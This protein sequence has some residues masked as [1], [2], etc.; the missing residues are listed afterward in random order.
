[1]KIIIGCDHGGFELK[2]KIAPLLISEGHEV[3]DIGVDSLESVDY[4]LYAVRVGKAVAGGEADR[5]VLICG[6]GIGMCIAANRVPGVR[7]VNASEP[8]SAKMSRHHNDSNVLCLGG[9][10]IGLDMAV[11]IVS[12]WLKEPFDGGRHERRVRLID[13]LI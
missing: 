11:E 6:S 4:P 10:F 2:A 13:E 3:L 8:Y 1:M 12:V 7:A 9:R 5:G